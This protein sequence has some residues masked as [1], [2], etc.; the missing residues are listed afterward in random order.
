MT[1]T[2]HALDYVEINVGDLAA[3]SRFYAGAFGW[4][5]NDY[6]PSYAGI[7]GPDGDG[8]VGGLNATAPGGPGGPLVLLWSDDLDA[9]AAAVESA[10][11]RVVDQPYEFPGGRRFRFA[12]PDGNELG[13]WSDR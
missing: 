4:T 2:H 10:G 12:D 13:V 7:R 6:G 9:T 1:H 3:A 11:G 5:F 8:E